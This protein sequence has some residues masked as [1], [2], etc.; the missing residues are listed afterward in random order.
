[1]TEY[2]WTD[3]EHFVR[4]EA[5]LFRSAALSQS[6][7]LHEDL[8]LTGDGAGALM[9][10]FFEAFPVTGGDYDFHRYF[11]MEGEGLLYSFFQ[12]FIMRKSHTFRRE[13]LTLGMLYQAILDRKWDGE[14]LARL[15]R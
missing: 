11:L 14:R 8:N 10:S 13:P 1:M 9:A 12:R 7:R 5:G 6:T 15:G 2:S 4:N 3:F